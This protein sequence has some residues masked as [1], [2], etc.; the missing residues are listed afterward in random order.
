MS[1]PS[2]G[3]RETNAEV[4]AQNAVNHA[5]SALN[6]AQELNDRGAKQRARERLDEA[7]LQEQA[8]EAGHSGAESL[9]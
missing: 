5:L 2:S 4:Q 9:S 3:Q 8:A 6:E 1:N 7:R